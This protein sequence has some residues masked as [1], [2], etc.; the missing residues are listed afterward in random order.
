MFVL[1]LGVS[2]LLAFLTAARAYEMSASAVARL[3]G[4]LAREF[5]KSP[6]TFLL[7]PRQEPEQG[8]PAPAPH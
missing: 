4:H 1:N 5:V 2:F 7:P 6:R 3:L 8:A